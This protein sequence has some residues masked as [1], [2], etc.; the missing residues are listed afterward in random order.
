MALSSKTPTT[1]L[2]TLVALILATG[3]FCLRAA[4]IFAAPVDPHSSGSLYE[5]NLTELLE[6]V[7]GEGNVRLSVQ[8]GIETS[9]LVLINKDSVDS[10]AMAEIEDITAIALGL[11]SNS[12]QVKLT[13]IAFAE[14]PGLPSQVQFLELTGLGLLCLVLAASLL[15][16]SS[17]TETRIAPDLRQLDPQPAP[18]RRESAILP[19]PSMELDQAASLAESDP[20]RTA[21]I[22][23]S[24]MNPRKETAA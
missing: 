17:Q 24:W 18:Q 21:Q 10:A 16:P 12:E 3:V 7:A 6:T 15:V 1:R 2:L 19:A 11:A 8:P 14:A 23:R 9:A 22:L 20:A 4:D 5:R 13:E